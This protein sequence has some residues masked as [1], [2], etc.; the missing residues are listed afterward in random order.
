M[1]DHQEDGTPECLGVG[2]HT[3]TSHWLPTIGEPARWVFR[4]QRLRRTSRGEIHLQEMRSALRLT[5]THA[6]YSNCAHIYERANL[7]LVANYLIFLH[8]YRPAS[9]S[10]ALAASQFSM[11]A[12]SDH[13]RV[14]RL[15]KVLCISTP[16]MLGG[17]C[18]STRSLRA[19]G[20]DREESVRGRRRCHAATSTPK[21]S[22]RVCEVLGVAVSDSA[23]GTGD[24]RH[25][26][27]RSS[28]RRSCVCATWEKQPGC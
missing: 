25:R 16:L 11:V 8:T 22:H 24:P 7:L 26:C 27:C 13:A 23:V 28:I 12:S 14:A 19:K 5:A 17:L 18:R 3:R 21:E 15:I 1:Q 9:L 20:K 6:K 4:R 10:S 2:D